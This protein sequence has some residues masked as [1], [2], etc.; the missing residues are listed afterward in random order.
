MP[1]HIGD[2]L[3]DTGH[4]RAA[5]VGSY[6]LLMFHYWSTGGLPDSDDQLAAIARMSRGEWNKNKDTLQAFFKDGWKHGRIDYDLEKAR[7]ISE[8]AREAGKASGRS[9]SVK[10]PLNDRSSSVEPTLEPSNHPKK[11]LSAGAS[12]R[13]ENFEAFWA[14][15]PRRNGDNPKAP[16]AKLFSGAVKAGANPQE[17]IDAAKKFA[18]AESKNIGTQ[19]IPQTVKWLRNK[20]WLDFGPNGISGNSASVFDI[21]SHLV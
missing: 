8:A 20:R 7:N 12:V 5:G 2:L 16:S 14:A 19:F 18:A 6:L 11:S 17:I 1:I 9:R 21:R 10:P 3:R 13:D 15:Y 4:L